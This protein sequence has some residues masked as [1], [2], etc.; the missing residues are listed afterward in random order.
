[1][2]PTVEAVD[3]DEIVVEADPFL[4][5]LQPKPKDF[6]L[7][8]KV[9]V[10]WT[11][12]N[13]VRQYFEDMY[14]DSDETLFIGAGITGLSVIN[15]DEEAFETIK[16]LG[17]AVAFHPSSP[18]LPNSTAVQSSIR[19]ALQ[20][21]VVLEKLGIYFPSVTKVD[22]VPLVLGNRG[23]FGYGV[24]DEEDSLSSNDNSLDDSASEKPVPPKPLPE[25]T[26][27][28]LDDEEDEDERGITTEENQIAEAQ[29]T[30]Q[31]YSAGNSKKT[32]IGLSTGVALGGAIIVL[33][34]ALLFES[35]RRRMDNWRESG[36]DSPPS[37]EDKAGKEK[38]ASSMAPRY[39]I[40]DDSEGALRL[41]RIWGVS[42]SQRMDSGTTPGSSDVSNEGDS[43]QDILTC[44]SMDRR[45]IQNVE[46][47]EHQKRLV[48]TLKKEMMASNAEVHPYMQ[49][50]HLDNTEPC[51]LSPTDLSAAA[52]ENTT[53][54]RPVPNWTSPSDSSFTGSGS[55]Y[56]S[57]SSPLR[58]IMGSLRMSS[59]QKTSSSRR[60]RRPFQEPA[61]VEL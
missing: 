15:E 49:D 29:T 2:M 13:I 28:S 27:S 12:E 7:Q 37:Q 1:M 3:D 18:L 42:P 25:V 53:P 61:A 44:T 10:L 51:A 20:E 35:R 9:T 31:T 34:I 11:V 46:S 39:Y 4:L 36:R 52:L 58:A 6:S 16:F 23:N 5:R 48:D 17:G 30:S 59:R 8:M 14:G 56:D 22:Y 26:R 19:D 33:L 54:S 57:P 60:S 21:S 38:P 41:P 24:P 43:V 55:G 40:E 47:F 32:T 45:S 50:T